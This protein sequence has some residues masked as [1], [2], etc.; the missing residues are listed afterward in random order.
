MD[1]RGMALAG[2][3]DQC[4]Q[5]TQKYHRRQEFREEFC[6]EI[7]RRAICE[8]DGDAW[9][10]LVETYAGLTRGWII[11][12]P[13]RSSVREDDDFLVNGLFERFLRAIGPDRFDQFP[14]L[15]NI[16]NYLKLCAHSVVMDEVRRRETAV[17]DST[18]R[19]LEELGEEPGAESV[20]L[21]NVGARELWERINR[22]LVDEAERR[23]IYLRLALGLAPREVQRREPDR[24]AT[25][26]DVYRVYR[27][28]LDRLRRAPDIREFVE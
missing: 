10:A 20:E 27:N 26:A 28:A 18:D 25:V 4:R 13:A 1:V 9:S 6:Y 2:L 3:A 16:L 7:F 19:L 21:E 23:V 15:A 14:T 12:H 17:V 22:A 24:F 11:R 8:R 5:E